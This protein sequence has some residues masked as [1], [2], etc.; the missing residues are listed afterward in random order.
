MMKACTL[1]VQSNQIGGLTSKLERSEIRAIYGTRRT[2]PGILSVF[3]AYV[4]Y[5]QVKA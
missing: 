3:A 2:R 5:S 1:Q 4:R